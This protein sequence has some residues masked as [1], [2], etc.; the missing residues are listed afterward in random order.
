MPHFEQ[1]KAAAEEMKNTENCKRRQL[2]AAALE[3]MRG[4]IAMHLD[5]VNEEYQAATD[6]YSGNI[7]A[8]KLEDAKRLFIAVERAGDLIG[9]EER[10]E[11]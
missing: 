7:A 6:D 10:G 11:I 2:S 1:A 3:E 8:M 4:K 9:R 5:A